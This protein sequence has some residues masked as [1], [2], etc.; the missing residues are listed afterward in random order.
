MAE[1]VK[2]F[3]EAGDDVVVVVSAMSGETNRLI[4]LANQIME[5][6]VPARTGRHGLDRRAGDHRP[7]QH[8]PDQARRA[9][10]LL[11]RQPGAYPH[12]QR[13]HKA[14]ILHIDDTHIRADL[15][16]GRVVVVA[17]FQGVDGNGNITTLGR[18]GSDTTGVALAAA[19]KADECRPT[20][21]STASTPPIRA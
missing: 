13:A 20:P 11:Y 14:R 21:T 12:R 5:Q 19:L 4:G 3:R 1:K 6:P 16:A 18:G 2:K 9:G 15:K 10:G 17:G 7:A 8:G